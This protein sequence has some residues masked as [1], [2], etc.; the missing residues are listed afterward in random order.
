MGQP[1]ERLTESYGEII[2]A[3]V[4]CDRK[5]FAQIEKLPTDLEIFKLLPKLIAL[6]YRI[7]EQDFLEKN[8]KR[9]LLNLGH[10]M[11]HVF[12]SAFGWPMEFLYC[13]DCSFRCAGAFIRGV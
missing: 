13:W 8:G 7:V 4:L 1:P 11:G 2:K 9:R 6:K 10:T 5:L 12:E 3:A